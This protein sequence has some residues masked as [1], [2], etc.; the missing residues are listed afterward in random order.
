MTL[1]KKSNANGNETMD[2]NFF[3]EVIE[4]DDEVIVESIMAGFGAGE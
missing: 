3:G 2:K 4:E 1:G